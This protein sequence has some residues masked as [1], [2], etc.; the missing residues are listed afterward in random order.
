MVDTHHMSAR[1]VQVSIDDQLLDR[2]DTD[3]DVIEDGRSA[4]IRRAV[5]FYIE[6]RRRHAVD[7]QLRSAFGG[8]ADEQ[9]AEVDQLLDAQ[10]WPPE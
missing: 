3:P 9:L 2:I 5:R 4:F 6:A 8:H 1:A 7:E 10:S